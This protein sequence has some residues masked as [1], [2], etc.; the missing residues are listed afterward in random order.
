MVQVFLLQPRSAKPPDPVATYPLSRLLP[1]EV[2]LPDSAGEPS[3]ED[4]Q[5]LSQGGVQWRGRAPADAAD[6]WHKSSGDVIPTCT[7]E[8]VGG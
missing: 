4:A 7:E 8:P 1:R 5:R 3:A 6:G 2:L